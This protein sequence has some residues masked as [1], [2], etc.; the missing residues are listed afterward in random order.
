[1]AGRVVKRK[2]ASKVQVREVR[3]RNVWKNPWIVIGIVILIVIVVGIVLS[4][5]GVMYGPAPCALAAYVSTDRDND[6]FKDVCGDTCVSIYNPDQNNKYCNPF[7]GQ[8]LTKD[9][10]NDN[11]KIPNTL[12]YS[13]A[14]GFYVGEVA[15]QEAIFTDPKTREVNTRVGTTGAVIKRKFTPTDLNNL[16]TKQG[17]SSSPS[18]SPSSS[19]S[20]SPSS[21]P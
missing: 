3:K 7:Y 20:P 10:D 13:S 21:S 1:M 2:E 14:L 4:L 17:T 11:D 12:T 5:K 6:G 9:Q 19:S 8:T 18:P 15:G 16:A